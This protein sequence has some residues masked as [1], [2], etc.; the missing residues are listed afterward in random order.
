[1]GNFSVSECSRGGDTRGTK[2]LKTTKTHPKPPP[3]LTTL[4]RAFP[5]FLTFRTQTCDDA[6]SDVAD[7]T[8][9][10]EGNCATS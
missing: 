5:N 7:P 1:M 4:L 9:S 8:G 3:P 2:R 10:S 6:I